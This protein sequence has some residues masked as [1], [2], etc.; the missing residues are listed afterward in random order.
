VP[1]E[2]KSAGGCADQER[3]PEKRGAEQAPAATVST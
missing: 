1:V 2:E 3:P